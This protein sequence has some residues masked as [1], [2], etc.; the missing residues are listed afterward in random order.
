LSWLLAFLGFSAL[1]ILHELGHLIAAKSV[2]MRVEKFSLF[3][4]KPIASFR[5]GE[6]EYAIGRYPVGGMVKITGM[7]PHEELDP[8]VAHRA[9]MRQ[10][11]WKRIFVIAA[12]PAVNVVLAFLIFAVLFM[13]HGKPEVGASV[14]AV[15]RGW[16]AQSVLRAGDK[17]VSVDGVADINGFAKQVATHKCA[18]TPRDGCLATTPARVVI[19]RGGERRSLSITPRYDANVDRSA[20]GKVTGRTR[21]G[22]AFGTSYATLGPLSAAGESASTMWRVTRITVQAIVRIFYDSQARKDVSGPVGSYE[23][24]RQTIAR[25]D[26]VL[27][28]QI[29]GL[30]SL[31]LAVVNLFPFLPLDGGHI[32]WAAAEKLRGRAIPFRVMERASVIGFMLIIVLFAVGLTNDLGR[33]FGEGFGAP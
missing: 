2:G 30:I 17:I 14:A 1:I 29:L 26:T 19:E 5:R 6:T 10:P 3:F 21:L 27:A 7:S 9:F 8:D 12:G 13:V 24:T 32:F 31:S 16:P 15:E 20:D 22:F 33:I 11:V 4:G 23:V 18:G 28:V 25:G